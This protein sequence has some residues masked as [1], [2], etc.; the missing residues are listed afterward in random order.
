MVLLAY[1][2]RQLTPFLK[3]S[4]SPLTSTKARQNIEIV[5]MPFIQRARSSKRAGTPLSAS[6]RA[7]RCHKSMSHWGLRADRPGSRW[8]AEIRHRALAGKNS[9]P[10]ALQ[11]RRLPR[12]VDL[13]AWAAQEGP[14]TNRLRLSNTCSRLPWDKCPYSEWTLL[15]N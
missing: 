4:C 10:P 9:R 5:I 14:I 1:H 6:L 12:R 11:V 7:S 2:L 8:A 15:D 13:R 3:I